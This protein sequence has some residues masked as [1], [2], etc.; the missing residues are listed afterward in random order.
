MLLWRSGILQVEWCQRELGGLFLS[1]FLRLVDPWRGVR[2]TSSG[3]LS[4]ARISAGSAALSLFGGTAKSRSHGGAEFR[5]LVVRE[6]Q[7]KMAV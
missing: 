4:T 6:P 3:E 1:L 7:A 2:S 5:L